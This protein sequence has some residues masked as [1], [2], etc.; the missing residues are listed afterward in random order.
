LNYQ[1]SAS[2]SCGNLL[3]LQMDIKQLEKSAIT[4]YHLD[5]CDGVFAPTFLLSPAVVKA[6]RP[7]TK[8]RLDV[9]IYGHH[10]SL[11][12]QE[13]KECGAD[14]V[15]VQVEVSGEDYKDTLQKI[16]AL[17]MT[18]GI[19]ILPTS[20]VPK[21]IRQVLPF[22]SIVVANTVGPAYAGQAFDPH[23]LEN[24]KNIH[25][26]ASDMG[27]SLELIADGGVSRE[28]LPLLLEAGAC[29]FV[30]GT[31]A[32]FFNRRLKSNVNSFYRL[33]EKLADSE[34]HKL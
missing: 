9:H 26:I 10:P 15:I 32:L 20:E 21:E 1:L 4:C 27:L 24:L 29:H 16:N 12:L 14:V 30:M 18:A 2:L 6:M 3:N 5:F 13:L 25:D 8:K 33:L 22:A 7:L 28:T 19:G 17:G 34:P 11:Y 23:G 31:K